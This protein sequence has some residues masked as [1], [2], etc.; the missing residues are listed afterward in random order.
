MRRILYIL[1]VV[2]FA[3]ILWGVPPKIA[4]PQEQSVI[5]KERLFIF[6]EP[7]PEDVEERRYIQIE[8]YERGL[9]QR[10]LN[11][12]LTPDQNYKDSIDVSLWKNGKYLLKVVYTDKRGKHLTKSSWRNI[13]VER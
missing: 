12:V 10:V 6:I 13:S 5:T 1:L 7:T 9:G 4:Q 2:G 11:L 3:Q 8:I